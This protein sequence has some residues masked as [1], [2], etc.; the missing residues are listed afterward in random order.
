MSAELR[1]VLGLG[2]RLEGVLPMLVC[3]RIFDLLFSSVQV[4]AILVASSMCAVLSP[5]YVVSVMVTMFDKSSARLRIA[6]CLIVSC[7]FRQMCLEAGPLCMHKTGV[8]RLR[9]PSTIIPDTVLQFDFE[10][11][12]TMPRMQLHHLDDESREKL[13]AARMTTRANI[14]SDKSAAR[15]IVSCQSSPQSDTGGSQATM[16]VSICCRRTLLR[17]QKF[18]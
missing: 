10:I 17:E 16:Q 1:W 12:L 4:P 11:L 5:I 15:L 7:C 6:T 9:M 18:L 3:E 14:R 8:C 2:S 13:R